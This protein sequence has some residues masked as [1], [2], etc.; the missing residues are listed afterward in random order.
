MTAQP[1]YYAKIWNQPP[2]LRDKFRQY[3]NIIDAAEKDVARSIIKE[4]AAR[5]K[6]NKMRMAMK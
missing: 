2:K 4:R 3:V 5:A 6:Y 1:I